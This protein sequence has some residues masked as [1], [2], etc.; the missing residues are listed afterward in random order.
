MLPEGSAGALRGHEAFRQS[1]GTDGTRQIHRE[2]RVLV[3]GQHDQNLLHWHPAGSA[4]KIAVVAAH[5][6]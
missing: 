4:L 1:G 6:I 2:S 5:F 3:Y